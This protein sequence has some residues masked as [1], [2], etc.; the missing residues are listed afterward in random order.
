MSQKKVDKY[1]HEKANRAK[2]MKKEKLMHRLEMTAVT[3][4]VVILLG[5]FGY[6]VYDKVEEGRPTKQYAFDTTSLDNYI[7]GL[8]AE[9]TEEAT[10]EE[11][12]EPT[13]EAAEP[14]EAAEATE[15]AE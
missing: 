15:Q 14:T 8:T 13:E 4:V 12:A 3:L 11:T 7:N 10:E 5:W 1:K 9:E 2:I 6:S